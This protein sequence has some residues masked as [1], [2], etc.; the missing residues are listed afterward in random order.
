MVQCFF[1]ETEKIEE[2]LHSDPSIE[3]FLW[4]VIN[5]YLL[6]LHIH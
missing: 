1:I 5:K 3:I 6:I 4:Q 2:L